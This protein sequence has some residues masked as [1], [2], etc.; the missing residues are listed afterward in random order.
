M[1]TI[2]GTAGNDT[3]V[4]TADA[5][6]I[7]GLGGNDS[8]LDEKGGV[9]TIHGGD[10]D[11]TITVRRGGSTGASAGLG[12]VLDGGA[13][14][15]TIV[16]S[17]LSGG[18]TYSFDMFGGAGND[19]FRLTGH[20]LSVDAGDGDDLIFFSARNFDATGTVR[21]GAGVDIISLEIGV[22]VHVLDV[23]A[24]DFTT[25]NGGDQIDLEPSLLAVTSWDQSSNPFAA[26]YI[27]LAQNGSDTVV[28]IDPDG[29]AGGGAA[30]SVLTL[31]NI[32]MTALTA[33][34]FDGYAPDGS[35][36]APQTINGTS[37]PDRL[38][39]GGGADTIRGGDGDDR[40]DGGA[41]A[42]QIFGDGGNDVLDG[43][44][45]SDE[46]HG[47]DG[48]DT[49]TDTAGASA[50]IYGDAGNDVITVTRVL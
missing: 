39:G 28:S 12:N 43:G 49:I 3:L 38:S 34:N 31:Q 33:W 32:Q 25:G 21:T 24:F 7:E 46:V 22:V 36:P 17:I 15:D 27:L 18:G 35:P 48:N 26:G 40:I 16:L 44:P 29:S 14:D 47:G 13:G 20:C 41:G 6:L 9:D 30:R 50:T 42:D 23:I 2:T 19:V 1:P 37:G 11:D 10:G 5:D 4:G 45:G 8:I